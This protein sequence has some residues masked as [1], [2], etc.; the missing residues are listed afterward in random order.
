[1]E[2]VVHTHIGKKRTS[3]Q[4]YADY[5]VSPGKQALL[6]LCDGVGG[7]LAGDVASKKTTEF[8]GQ[9][10][11]TLKDPL[12]LV[13]MKDWLQVIMSQVNQYISLE[14][15]NNED[16]H[17]M[18]TTLVL[19]TQVED[20]L[21]VAHVGDSRAYAY[22]NQGQL[23]RLTD[24]H[25]L[26]NELI[27]SGQITP[28]EGIN[29]PRRNVV[30]QSIGQPVDLKTEVNNFSVEDLRLLLLC[31][32]GLNTMVSDEEIQAIIQSTI[33]LSDLD[34]LA[35]R[36]IEAANE[37]GGLDNITLIL[38]KDFRISGEEECHD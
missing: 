10:F 26:V 20:Q 1:M 13:Q 38:A 8:I 33:D 27:R 16:Q 2:I 6:I 5:F 18:G 11:L 7:N 9:H 32:D 30:T 19:A 4:D 23:I 12:D 36:L 21:L 37:A 28:E 35:D 14:A 24:D 3:N 29:H 15:Q 22:N 25:S 31:S 17:G 34:Y